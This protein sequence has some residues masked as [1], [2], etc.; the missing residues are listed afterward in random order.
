MADDLVEA[1]SKPNP[2]IKI[3]VDQFLYRAFLHAD[4]KTVSKKCLK[5]LSSIMVKVSIELLL[6]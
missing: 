3:Q 2:D 4:M 1:A 5:D 6:H